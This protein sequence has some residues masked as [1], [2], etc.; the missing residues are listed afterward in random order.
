[1]VAH[2]Q[3]TTTMNKPTPP[4]DGECCENGC[5]PCIWDAYYA[6]LRAWEAQQAA[7]AVVAHD[8]NTN[9]SA[10]S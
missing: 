4:A 1:M 7:L 10:P 6:A 3:L 2:L 8:T 9:T 5:D